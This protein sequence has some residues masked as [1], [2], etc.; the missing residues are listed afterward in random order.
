MDGL[1]FKWNKAKKDAASSSLFVGT[2]PAFDFSIFSVCALAI[3][4]APNVFR[5][6]TCRIFKSTLTI[7]A[8]QIF[9]KVRRV[10][11]PTEKVNTAYPSS[12]VGK[13]YFAQARKLEI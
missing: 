10:Q 1:N 9:Q 12:V 4:P 5:E 6:C 11:T 13:L 7:R 2:S 8:Q 3:F